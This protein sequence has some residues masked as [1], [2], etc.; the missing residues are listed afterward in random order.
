MSFVKSVV[1]YSSMHED[2][3]SSACRS[4]WKRSIYVVLCT[5][6]RTPTYVDERSM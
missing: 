1:W 4:T 2:E 3:D 5:S 6:Y